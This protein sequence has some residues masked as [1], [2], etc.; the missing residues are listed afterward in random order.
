MFSHS[1]GRRRT[2]CPSPP[3]TQL[4]KRTW[5]L[6]P[7]ASAASTAS[8]TP[9]RAAR[10]GLDYGVEHEAGRAAVTWAAVS[11]ICAQTSLPPAARPLHPSLASVW[12]QATQPSETLFTPL[13]FKWIIKEVGRLHYL[14]W[15]QTTARGWGSVLCTAL[16][17]YIKVTEF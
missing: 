1:D 12:I 13:L 3:L 4:S 5:H 8:Q 16:V 7:T 9:A 6:V 15:I 10:S 2:H 11:I 14:Y 17:C